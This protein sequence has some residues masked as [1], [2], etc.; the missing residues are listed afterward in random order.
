MLLFYII[1]LSVE[2]RGGRGGGRGGRDGGWLWGRRSWFSS[3]RS[4]GSRSSSSSTPSTKVKVVS[5]WSPPKTKSFTDLKPI[6]ERVSKTRTQTRYG[7]EFKEKT[8]KLMTKRIANKKKLFGLGVGAAFIG[9]AGFGF[10]SGLASYSIYHR[11]HYLQGILQAKGYN[12]EYWDEDY[13]SKY[14]EK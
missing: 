4:G 10:G 1:I 5:S 2:A 9:G 12:E 6:I 11:Y 14:Y 7:T 13:Y 3:G 8:T